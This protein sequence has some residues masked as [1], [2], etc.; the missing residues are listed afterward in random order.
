MSRRWPKSLTEVL[1]FFHQSGVISVG[2]VAIDGSLIA[3]D[4][5]AQQTKT[6]AS[7]CK[8]IEAILAEA[9]EAEAADDE[10]FGDARGDELPPELAD[11]RPRRERLRR[12]RR[13][14]GPNRPPSPPPMRPSWSDWEAERPQAR[15]AQAH[16][17][18]IPRR[19]TPATSTPPT[20][21]AG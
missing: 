7:I 1:V 21:T 16:A 6:Y 10:R 15:R 4:A 3:G 9:A 8:E 14:S 19:S 5:S 11:P 17:A 20:L 12:C 13:S 18:P 2:L